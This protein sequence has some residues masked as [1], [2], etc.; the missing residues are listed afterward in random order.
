MY[1]QLPAF[2]LDRAWV[3]DQD[4]NLIPQSLHHRPSQTD[5]GRKTLNQLIN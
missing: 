2:R 1:V 3:N 4:S 5:T